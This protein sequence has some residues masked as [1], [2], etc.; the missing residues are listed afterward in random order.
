MAEN[1]IVRKTYYTRMY[2]AWT[3]MVSIIEEVC[4]KDIRGLDTSFPKVL[5]GVLSSNF[6]DTLRGS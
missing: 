2:P 4:Y 5:A 3:T 1:D 6:S